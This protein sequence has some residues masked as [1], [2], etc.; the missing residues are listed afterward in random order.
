[1]LGTHSDIVGG[2]LLLLGE[3]ETDPTQNVTTARQPVKF[4]G[5]SVMLAIIEILLMKGKTSLTLL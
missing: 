4:L 3:L 5:E 1:M 2:V